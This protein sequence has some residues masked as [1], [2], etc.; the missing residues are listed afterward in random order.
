MRLL[1]FH[2]AIL[3]STLAAVQPA[4]SQQPAPERASFYLL[5]RGDTI[6]EEREDRT[7]T[8]LSGEFRDRLR[9]VRVSYDAALNSSALVTRLNLRTFRPGQVVPDSA[10][11]T[12]RT[13]GT[14][15]AASISERTLRISERVLTLMMNSLRRTRWTGTSTFV[16]DAVYLLYAA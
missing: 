1:S 7:P 12:M 16:S 8:A 4:R 3:L 13:E 10:S 15:G 5:L 6:F 14:C 9:N 11:F 2:R